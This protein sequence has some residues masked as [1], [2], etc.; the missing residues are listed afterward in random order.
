MTLLQQRQVA[1]LACFD[2]FGKT[3]I[4][5]LAHC[6]AAGATT[7]LHLLELPGRRLSR[8]QLREIQRIDRRTQV[9]QHHWRDLRSVLLQLA[10]HDALVLGLDGQRSRD[11][12]LLSRA[13]WAER[14][15]RP[16]LVSAYP[17]ILFRHQI[18]GM[19]D[20]SG[21]ELLCLNS[22]GD[23]ELY[24]QAC[25]AMGI[26]AGNAV[27]TG[28]PILWSL[29]PRPVRPG[30]GSIVFFEQ[31]SVPA[32]PLQRTY[33]ARRLVEL[34]A[35]HPDRPVIFKPRTSSIEATLHR[36]HGEMASLLVPLQ[37]RYPNLQ[38]SFR[39]SLMLLRR[40]DCAITVSSTA[41][42]EAMAM[43]ISTRLVADFG[44]CE[45]LGN[46][47][48]AKSGAVADFDA[49]AADPFT[50]RHDAHWLATH[51]CLPDGADRFLEALAERLTTP[52][53]GERSAG[54]G[55]AGWGSPTW[56]RYALANGGR[57]MLTSAGAR[58]RHRARH[59]GKTLL[60][61]LREQVV[62]LWGLEQWL[63][64]R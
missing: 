51:G 42:M 62:G 55:P 4:Q 24:R 63:K 10:G 36:R 30:K 47:Y 43:G 32:N 9:V 31:P 27:V 50:P 39:P 37:R 22:P 60:R 53:A 26:D 57:R 5:I 33:V 23:A 17:G 28:L 48:F 8:R 18:E 41:A 44:V 40:C 21:V 35:A 34:A 11:L 49:I 25:Q 52:P 56:Q 38:I 29:K 2:S 16:V 61:R 1:A 13:T 59:R 45:T 7:T 20:R 12:L 6:R 3:A 15:Q 64:R 58:S 14:Q 46:H 54:A 19:L